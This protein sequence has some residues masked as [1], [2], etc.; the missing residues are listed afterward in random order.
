MGKQRIKLLSKQR[1]PIS[2]EIVRK[3]GGDPVAAFY[4]RQLQY[5]EK[6]GSDTSGWFSKNSKEVENDT[7]L[8]RRRQE[9]SRSKLENIG[10]I[11]TR[12]ERGGLKPTCFFRIITDFY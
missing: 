3:L 2:P 10:W 6:Y 5:Y 7:G 12:T 11:E 1:V 4:Y 8:N 9:N